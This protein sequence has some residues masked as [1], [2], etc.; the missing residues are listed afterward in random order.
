MGAGSTYKEITKV[1]T[2]EDATT[3]TSIAHNAG[4]VMLIDFWATWCPPCQAPMDHNQKMLDKNGEDWKKK[5]IRIIGLSIDQSAD[6]VVTHVETKGWKSVEHYHRAK[7]DCSDVYGVRGVPHVM[8]VDQKGTI[9]FK[10]HPAGRKSL[11]EDL[12]KLAKGEE[13]EGEGIHKL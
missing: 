11:E 3:E 12:E 5:Q 9:V 8:L 6:K 1:T 4:D 10:G 2:I 13:L 7:S